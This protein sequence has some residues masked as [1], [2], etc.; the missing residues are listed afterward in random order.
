MNILCFDISTGGLTAAILNEQLN[1]LS[2]SEIPW[3]ISTNADGA[4]V[5]DVDLF[6]RA[7]LESTTTIPDKFRSDI[8]AISFSAFMHNYTVLDGRGRP[9]TPI[10]TWMDRRGREGVDLVRNE[11]GARFHLLTG[12]RYHPMFPVFKLASVEMPMAGQIVS[13]K[14]LAVAQLT[15]S[16]AEDHGTASAT[17]LYD[18]QRGTWSEEILHVIG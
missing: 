2:T 5:V 14:S 7:M 6:K 11:L 18:V 10:F 8:D 12:C 13:A 17:G 1:A 4:A 9:A 3:Q 15:G 16:W